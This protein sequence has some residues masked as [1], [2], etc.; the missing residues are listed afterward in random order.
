MPHAARTM[1]FYRALAHITHLEASTEEPDEAQLDHICSLLRICHDRIDE[2]AQSNPLTF[3]LLDAFNPGPI[4]LQ[5]RI[6]DL[7]PRLTALADDIDCP[8]LDDLHMAVTARA[9]TTMH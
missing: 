4:S 5:Q 3:D 2:H 6:R 9:P 8:Q 7:I 1:L